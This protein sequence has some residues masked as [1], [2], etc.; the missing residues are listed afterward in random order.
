V[1][2]LKN[3]LMSATKEFKEVLTMRT[4]V[5]WNYTAL[6]PPFWSLQYRWLLKAF[7]SLMCRIWRFMKIEGKCSP[8][9]LQRMHQI[10]SFVNVPLLLGIR[11][12]PLS[13]QHHG[14]V[15]LHLR[16]CS[17]GIVAH[18]KLDAFVFS[19]FRSHFKQNLMILYFH[20]SEAI[21]PF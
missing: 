18:T 4:E 16:H 21:P 13:L 10:H 11:P 3:R 9:Q 5:R 12:N 15:T 6:S 7:L 20:F 14:P 1:D 8:H 17:R 19:P 2:N